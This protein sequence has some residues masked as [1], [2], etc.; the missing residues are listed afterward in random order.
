MKNRFFHLSASLFLTTGIFGAVMNAPAQAKPAQNQ[1]ISAAICSNSDISLGGVIA[2]ACEGAFS[3]NDAGF[4]SDLNGG[5]FSS[6][7]GD[8]V[9]WSLAGKTDESNA[10]VTSDNGS[11]TGSWSLLQQ[12]SSNTF[13]VNLK[14]SNSY[15]AY[16]FQN[17]DW[18]Q[19]LSGL[20]NTIGV[21]VNQN[22]EAQELS[23]ASLFVANIAANQESQAV[24]EPATLLGLGLVASGMMIS[25]R[26]Q[27][28]C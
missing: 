28:S 14:T 25:R 15:S 17:Y 26:R 12:L 4:L 23:H 22:G 21:A 16:L 19:G 18:S 13:V 5:L 3:G 9:T 10:Y 7:V 6:N 24:P 11:A 20:F 8:G 27:S 2:T 1:T